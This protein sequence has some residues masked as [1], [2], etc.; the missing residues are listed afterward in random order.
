MRFTVQ[1]TLVLKQIVF[2]C[3]L[4]PK[5]IVFSCRLTP[6]QIVFSEIRQG[7]VLKNGHFLAIVIFGGLRYV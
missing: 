3:K 7:K 5:Q 1:P 4:E 2:S 6:E